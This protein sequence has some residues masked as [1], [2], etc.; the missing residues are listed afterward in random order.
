MI[1]VNLYKCVDK[2]VV[3]ICIII[4]FLKVNFMLNL[5]FLINL[6]LVEY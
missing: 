5:E 4:K 3:M 1:N 6:E 2:L